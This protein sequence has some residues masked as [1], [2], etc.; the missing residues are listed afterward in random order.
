MSD[1]QNSNSNNSN[2]GNRKRK[3]PTSGNNRKR[4]RRPR[5]NRNRKPTGKNLG[6][7][8]KVERAYLNLL[9]KHLEARRKYFDLFHRADPRQ[10]AKLERSFTRTLEELRE[11]EDNIKDELKDQ[12][13]AKYNSLKIDHTYCENH[14]ISPEVGTVETQGDF[15]DPH[16]LPT[17]IQADFKQDTE[18]SVGSIEDY[19]QYK[20]L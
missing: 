10:L 4:N 9:E 17:Q 6:G 8:E 18:E 14:E 20:G 15:D 13:N 11:Y 2:N 12:F 5:N 16:L 1:S 7:F 19:N 3:R